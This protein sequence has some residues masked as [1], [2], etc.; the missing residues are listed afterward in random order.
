MNLANLENAR[1]QLKLADNGVS[2]HIQD[3]ID[4]VD[5]AIRELEALPVVPTVEVGQVWVSV[6]DA[7]LTLEIL[8]VGNRVAL[9]RN[10]W[11]DEATICLSTI[12]KHYTL[13]THAPNPTPLTA[14]DISDGV[15]GAWIDERC[16]EI[17]Y[18]TKKQY[19]KRFLAA[20]INKFNE[21]KA[22]GV[23]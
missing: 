3:A 12:T 6:G 15:Y 5:S 18:E 21:E 7:D 16:K 23:Q 4:S 10:H 22:C 2:V 1:E 14:D 8:G 9:W 17:V 19:E 20:A 13:Q 11:G